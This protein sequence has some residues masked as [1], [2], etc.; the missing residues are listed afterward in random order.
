VR[1]LPA[2]VLGNGSLL[3]SVSASGRLLS[4][5]WPHVD[6]GQHL[7]ELRLGLRRDSAVRWLDEPP[8]GW[9]QEYVPDVTILRTTARADGLQVEVTDL[10]DPEEPVLLRRVG[11]PARHGPVLV[12][13]RPELDESRRGLGAYVDSATGALV[14]Y[15]RDRALALAFCGGGEASCRRVGGEDGLVAAGQVEGTVAAAA[16]ADALLVCAFGSAPAEA[17]AR[18][19]APLSDG[20]EQLAE[21]RRRHDSARLAR[22]Q[23]ADAAGPLYSRSLLVLDL[24]ADRTTGAIVAAP[25][26]DGDFQTS[27]GYG[28]VWARDMAYI[29]LALLAA[30]S[31]ELA[32]R[33][34]RWL[35]RAQSPEGLWLQRHDT[36]ARLAASW[37]LHQLDE[38]G[39]VVFAYE[40]AWWS[41]RDEELDGDLWPSARRAAELLASALDDRGLPCSTVDLW[42]EREGCHAYTAAAVFGGLSAAASMARRHEPELEDELTAAADRVR[43]GIERHLWS[44]E[45]G[46]Y[47]RAIPAAS[48]SLP[49]PNRG[50]GSLHED[51]AVDV[52][53]LG[54]AWPFGAVEPLGGRMRRTAAAIDRELVQPDGG[55]LRYGKDSY[56]GGN[57]WV[58]AA[59]WLGLWHRQ[60]GDDAGLRRAVAHAETVQTE[61]GLLAEQVAADGS[62]AWVLPLAW[63]HAMLILAVR[64]ELEAV[65]ARTAAASSAVRVPR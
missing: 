17:I 29:V 43:D 14:F 9:E 59:L 57:R 37:G 25:E 1:K 13:C 33:A 41:L 61:L 27:G 44:D 39:A 55:V 8:F 26:Q 42:E 45:R 21:A 53:L 34:L 4:L 12:Y 63:S 30:D 19:A 51:A 52:S 56:A 22:A 23:P 60:S 32:V 28:F 50:F 6:G 58:L 18:L 5:C 35:P 40:A 20:W 10:V 49:Y 16:D 15:R 64:P 48:G 36:A 31:R 11:C 46:R 2:A 54:L 24:L 3:A 7:G 47:L 62:P 38:T 65:R